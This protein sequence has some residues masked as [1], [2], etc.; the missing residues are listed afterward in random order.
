MHAVI[1]TKASP[2]KYVCMTFF[3]AW[4]CMYVLILV[5]LYITWQ[6]MHMLMSI[7]MER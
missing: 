3:M 4:L 2:T 6:Y 5:K 1:K 7:H